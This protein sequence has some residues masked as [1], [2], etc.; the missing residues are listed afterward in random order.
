MYIYILAVVLCIEGSMYG[1]PLSS[2]YAP[3]PTG[4]PH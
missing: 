3:T 1:F 4:V 2:R